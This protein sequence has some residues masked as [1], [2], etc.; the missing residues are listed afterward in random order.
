MDP[1]IYRK[2]RVTNIKQLPSGEWKVFTEN[3]DITCEHVVNAA[4]S[5]CPKLVEGLGLK[6]VPS[7][8]M[9]HHYLV[10]ES[11]PE[12]EKLEKELPVTRDPEASASLKTRRQRFINRS[13][14]KRCKTL[15]FRRN[16]LEI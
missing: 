9:I 10:T 12:I 14:R 4:G 15:G 16:G 11:H 8:N 13:I 2:N 3:G 1:K 5:F 7:I 6:D